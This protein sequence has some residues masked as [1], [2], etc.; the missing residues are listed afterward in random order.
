[1]AGA[2]LC[3]LPLLSRACLRACTSQRRGAIPGSEPEGLGPGHRPATSLHVSLPF[4]G[5]SFSQLLNRIC[6]LSS[7]PIGFPKKLFE[8][9][10]QSYRSPHSLMP[11]YGRGFFQ[12]E[13]LPHT[14]RLAVGYE[15]QLEGRGETGATC[16][17][18]SA[19]LV[20]VTII[21]LE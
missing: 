13:E 1:M 16:G 3:Q 20:P 10:F 5:P 6:Y 12:G 11:S 21:F 2:G 7:N 9:I 15:S 19:E 14:K 17:H 18:I 8:S 4:S